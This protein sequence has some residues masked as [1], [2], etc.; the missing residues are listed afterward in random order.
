[1]KSIAETCD[2]ICSN[3]F[4][5]ITFV[6]LAFLIVLMC[7]FASSPLFGLGLGD[8]SVYK[9]MGRVFL[10]GGVL[11]VDYFDHKGPYFYLFNAIGESISPAWGL[12]PLQAIWLSFSLIL[13]FKTARLFARPIYSFIVTLIAIALFIGIYEGGD[14]TEEFSLLPCSLS[15]YLALSFLLNHPDEK[16]DYWRSLVYGLCFGLA[17]LIRPNDA[18]MVCGGVMT[19]IFLYIIIRQKQYTTAILNALTFLLGGFI[20]FAPWIAYFAYHHALVDFYFGLIGFNMDYTG[21]LTYNLLNILEIKVLVLACIILVGLIIT[22]KKPRLL[23]IVIPVSIFI[24]LLFGRNNYPRY[25][26]TVIPAIFL[27]FFTMVFCQNIRKS[28]LIIAGVLLIIL[29]VS[30]IGI[31]RFTR[32]ASHLAEGSIGQQ[33]FAD[34]K[35]KNKEKD[36]LL[37]VPK[38]DRDSVWNYGD[39]FSTLFYLAN[40]IAQ[41]PVPP[42]IVGQHRPFPKEKEKRLHIT[43]YKPLWVF[44]KNSTY[45]FPEDS[46]FIAEHYAVVKE[47]YPKK[48]MLLKRKDE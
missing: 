47:S 32:I 3:K 16:H 4:F 35:E 31:G 43:L 6:V 28:V 26:I 41:N 29:G 34:K 45:F 33:F 46:A 21:G 24:I 14:L 7:S 36:L 19:G 5:P 12:F 38:E 2:R 13:W 22:A 39:E 20:M 40:I 18:V 23:W 37:F 11:Y 48:F 1:M 30:H 10:N 42:G 9:M 44:M 25:Y 8:S 15:V 27:L 17:F